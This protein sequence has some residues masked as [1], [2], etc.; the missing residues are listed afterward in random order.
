MVKGATRV[1]HLSSWLNHF[2][3]KNQKKI[4][5]LFNSIKSYLI[6][7]NSIIPSMHIVAVIESINRVKK[8]PI[9][10]CTTA[11]PK[12]PRYFFC[13]VPR[14]KL[15]Q[16]KNEFLVQFKR[17]EWMVTTEKLQQKKGGTTAVTKVPR[18]FFCNVPRYKLIQW[19]K[20]VFGAV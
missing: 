1:Q 19:K 11:V 17:L 8:N 7:F 15:I 16:G 10:G 4:K 18:Y 6:W 13:N 20:W 9:Q 3:K 14:Y 12:V 2:S 5:S